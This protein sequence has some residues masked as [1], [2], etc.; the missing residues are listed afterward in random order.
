MK[1][2]LHQVSYKLVLHVRV[3][4][5]STFPRWNLDEYRIQLSC[6]MSSKFFLGFKATQMIC[7]ALQYGNECLYFSPSYTL[8]RFG[9]MDDTDII[10][11]FGRIS[12]NSSNTGR[13]FTYWL[14][15]DSHDRF[16]QTDFPFVRTKF[17]NK[18]TS[19]KECVFLTYHGQNSVYIYVHCY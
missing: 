16:A 6:S 3:W 8:S 10:R 12:F 18:L 9:C 7:I 17:F 13:D 5:F 15:W 14:S 11:S 19:L 1:T 4:C 2:N